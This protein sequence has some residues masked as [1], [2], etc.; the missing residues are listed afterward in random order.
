[1]D[2]KITPKKTNVGGI[3]F[4]VFMGLIVLTPIVVGIYGFIKQ[5]EIFS[6]PFVIY[7]GIGELMIVF[8]WSLLILAFTVSMLITIKLNKSEMCKWVGI[9]LGLICVTLWI[10]FFEFYEEKTTIWYANNY[11]ISK[12]QPYVFC[13]G[14]MKTS[15]KS[16][17]SKDYVFARADIGCE[18]FKKSKARKQHTYR[19]FSK[20]IDELNEQF[21]DK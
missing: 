21:G 11:L 10:A 17:Y 15:G 6:E 8:V 20:K 19:E 18:P 14:R 2:N 7:S 13:D 4:F 9:I 5:N 16:S 12:E 1:M 3:I